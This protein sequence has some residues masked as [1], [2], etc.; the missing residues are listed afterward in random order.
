MTYACPT[1]EFPADTHLLKL[2]R[3]QNKVL[4]T[5][6]KFPKGTPVGELHM[7]FQIPYIYDDTTKFYRQ[8]AEII[9]NRE[10]A[11]DRD[12]GKSETRHEKYKRLKLGGG[13]AYDR[14]SDLTDVVI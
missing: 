5:T 11:N 1:W 10:N 2:Q 12:A 3:L 8:E 13:Q 7:D 4:L 6:G 9:Q 14:S